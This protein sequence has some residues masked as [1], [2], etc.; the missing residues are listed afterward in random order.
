MIHRGLRINLTNHTIVPHYR[1]I[2]R[3]ILVAMREANLLLEI[4]ET[5]DLILEIGMILEM[6]EVTILGLMVIEIFVIIIKAD[7]RTFYSTLQIPRCALNSRK[8][9]IKI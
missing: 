6:L 2:H 9:P 3:K 5:I 8:H 1:E 7:F 4:I